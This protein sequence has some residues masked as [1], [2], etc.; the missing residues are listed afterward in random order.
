MHIADLLKQVCEDNGW[1]Y[2]Y[3]S[4]AYLN[5]NDFDADAALPEN[6]HLLMDPVTINEKRNQDTGVLE[7]VSYTGGF[8][9]CV[10]ADLDTLYADKYER[11][12]KPLKAK[13]DTIITGAMNACTDYQ[14]VTWKL[15]EAVDVFDTNVSGYVVEYDVKIEL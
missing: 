9:F 4:R 3:G 14:V 5:L 10:K 15:T 7:S 2:K 11:Y 13:I 6:I 8:L 1:S 12:I